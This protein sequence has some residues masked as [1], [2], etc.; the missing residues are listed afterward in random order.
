MEVVYSELATHEKNNSMN[1]QD[2][3]GDEDDY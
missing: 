3:F 2:E 1:P